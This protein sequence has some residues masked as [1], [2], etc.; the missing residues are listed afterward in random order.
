MLVG[1]HNLSNSSLVEN[2]EVGEIVRS[3]GAVTTL[4]TRFDGDWSLG[5]DWQ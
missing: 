4:R 2:R 1:S 3:P 5:R